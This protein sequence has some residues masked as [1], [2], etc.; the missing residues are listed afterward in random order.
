[1]GGQG[2]DLLGDGLELVKARDGV[3]LLLAVVLG[4]HVDELASLKVKMKLAIMGS[5]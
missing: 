4:V 1:M 2:D 5:R 3:D